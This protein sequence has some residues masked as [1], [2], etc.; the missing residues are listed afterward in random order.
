VSVA[1]LFPGQGAQQV[2]MM[3][4]LA[5]AS[6]AAR[7]VFEMAD[8][9]LGFALSELCFAGP[10]EKLNATDMSQPAMFACSAAALAAMEE[11]IGLENLPQPTMMAGLSLGEYTALYAADAIDFSDALDLVTRRGAAMQAAAEDQPSGMLCILGLD[12]P[13]VLELCEAAGQG[14][15]L[16][17]AN[18]NCP[19]QIVISGDIDACGRAAEM[20]AE[21]G[22][23]G[24]VALKV[25]GAFHSPFMAPAAEKLS[26]AL[27]AAELRESRHPVIS[28]VDVTAHASPDDSRAKLAAQLTSPVRWAESMQFMLDNGVETFYEIGPGRVLARL[29]RRIS[30]RTK[31]VSLNSADA[32]AKLAGQLAC[33]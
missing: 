13:Q 32:I 30:R 18:F 12:E 8:E 28:N 9:Q 15:A 22:A 11:A 25:A 33:D 24:A 21:F 6:P 16:V 29:M 4:D 27:A 3:A 31:V 14:A 26:Q 23:S 5:E 10:E 1:F 2:G 20:A 7:R 19:G 17:P